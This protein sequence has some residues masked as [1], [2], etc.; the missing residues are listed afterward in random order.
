MHIIIFVVLFLL[1]LSSFLANPA[2]LSLELLDLVL[3]F[4]P[5]LLAFLS[6]VLAK[7][8]QLYRLEA[9]L[10]LAI[11][12]YLSYLLISAL[13]GILQGLPI[14]NVARS[15]GPYL[16]FFP[17]LLL[18]FL[19]KK[20]MRPK[21]LSFILISVGLIQ[22]GYLSYLYGGQATAIH[23]TTAVLVKR[24]TIL[25]QRTTVPFLLAVPILPLILLFQAQTSAKKNW[26]LKLLALA[27][28][29][30]GLFAGML[31]LTRAIFLSILFGWLVFALLYI[32]GQRQAGHFS[33]LTVVKKL[34]LYLP[35]FLVLLALLSMIPQIQLI[36]SGLFARFTSAAGSADYSDGRIYDEWLPALSN[37][38]N[39]DIVNILFGIGAGNSFTVLSGEERTY[40]HNLAL[41]SLVYGGF[42]GLFACCWLYFTTFK[43][44]L[45]RASETQNTNYLAYAAL[46][47]SLFFYGQLFAV[48]KSLTFNI[49]LFLI[50]GLA[51][52]A[53]EPQEETS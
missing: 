40:I 49:M 32:H 19:P 41:Y 13:I 45:T 4:L 43:T 39:S 18:G 9:N 10:I 38:A 46:L 14:L 2:P 26:L 24:I 3:I 15:I 53:N 52:Q 33:V 23:N 12:L 30:L 36:E 27:L 35:L 8:Y 20:V 16:N 51:L 28:M 1:V 25:D 47:A 48:H 31:T 5:C 37:W 21:T 44:L 11:I 50:M 7:T 34:S 6:M 17:L 42:F 22:I 29:M